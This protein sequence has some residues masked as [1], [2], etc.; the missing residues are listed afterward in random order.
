MVADTEIA[1]SWRNTDSSLIITMN[2]MG[3]VGKW[4]SRNPHSPSDMK[5]ITSQLSKYLFNLVNHTY[6]EP[7]ILY[8]C[9][10]LFVKWILFTEFLLDISHY[11]ISTLDFSL[12]Y[13]G[14]GNK[15]YLFVFAVLKSFH[16]TSYI[17]S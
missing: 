13:S 15:L 4:P 11:T 8:F 2:I 14:R 9:F 7:F 10:Q 1:C 6:F 5:N 12:W 17:T 16:D 3:G